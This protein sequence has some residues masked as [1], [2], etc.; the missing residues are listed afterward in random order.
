[1]CLST[2]IEVGLKR[3]PHFFILNIFE[4]GDEGLN[5]MED[6]SPRIHLNPNTNNAFRTLKSS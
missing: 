4:L 2:G 5:I 6:L 1:M 3:L